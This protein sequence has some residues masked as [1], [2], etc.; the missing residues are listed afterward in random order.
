MTNRRPI[1][2][3]IEVFGRWLILKDPTP[4][5]AVFGE[6]DMILLNLAAWLLLAGYWD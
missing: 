6:P 4:L 5:Y 2:E 1:D 3:V